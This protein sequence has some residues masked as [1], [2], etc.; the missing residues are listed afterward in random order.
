MKQADLNCA[1]V[2]LVE[3]GNSSLDEEKS[4]GRSGTTS[5]AGASLIALVL[6]SYF[7]KLY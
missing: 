4:G 7:L 6:C 5:R 2:L 3:R 1:N